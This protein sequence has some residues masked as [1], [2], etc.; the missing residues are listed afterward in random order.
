MV[1]GLWE[2]RRVTKDIMIRFNVKGDY[3]FRTTIIEW[4]ESDK[5]AMKANASHLVKRTE[6]NSKKKILEQKSCARAQHHAQIIDTFETEFL[7]AETTFNKTKENIAVSEKDRIREFVTLKVVQCLLKKIEDRNST[8]CDEETDEAD[9]I[10]KN[11][12]TTDVITIH[13]EIDYPCSPPR[14]CHD[15]VKCYP[16]TPICYRKE[17]FRSIEDFGS[18]SLMKS[19]IRCTTVSPCRQFITKIARSSM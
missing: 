3:Y 12:E 7:A 9:E 15:P 11:C 19:K 18:A 5:V 1:P 14:P 2:Y 10:I 6:C 17:H 4:M 16:G 13:L 8:K